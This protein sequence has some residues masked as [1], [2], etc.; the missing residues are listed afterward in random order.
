MA[1]SNNSGSNGRMNY[2]NISYGML[3]TRVKDVPEGFTQIKEEELKSS[4]KKVENVDLRNKYLEKS[5]DYPFNIYY[6]KIEGKINNIE[7]EEYSAGIS[8]KIDM[9]DLDGDNSIV[10]VKFYSKYTENLLNRLLNVS[11][12]NGNFA[13]TPY[14]IPTEFEPEPGKKISLYNQGVSLKEEGEKVEVK[15]KNDDK[16]LPATERVQ[17]AEGKLQTSRVNRINFLYDA[18]FSK[19]NGNTETST[20]KPKSEK[21]KPKTE[22]KKADEV[23]EDDLPF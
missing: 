5:G 12:V 7:K 23:D 15:Y 14:A 8:L 3:G 9:T 17:N 16:D 13:L 19:F 2:Y 4:T 11:N 22:S 18:V 10:Q 6:D 1:A 20:V 21:E